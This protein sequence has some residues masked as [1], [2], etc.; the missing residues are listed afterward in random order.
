MSA[1]TRTNTH[2]HTRKEATSKKILAD[3]ELKCTLRSNIQ[4][5]VHTYHRARLHKHT[6]FPLRLRD[7]VN[8]QCLSPLCA[9][10]VPLPSV[11]AGCHQPIPLSPRLA[12]HVRCFSC[13][14]ASARI[15]HEC[16]FKLLVRD[17]APSRLL[18]SPHPF[19]CVF[20]GMGVPLRLS[21]HSDCF[22][23]TW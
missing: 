11:V 6:K 13:R 4:E 8:L 18:A 2:N 22:R 3:T 1:H 17:R 21:K 12:V 16:V 7:N 5:H 15:L 20:L 9:L 23:R 10:P 14:V 19:T